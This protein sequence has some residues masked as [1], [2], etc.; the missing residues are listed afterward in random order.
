MI[1]RAQGGSLSKVQVRYF[2]DSDSE[3]EFRSARIS[4]DGDVNATV[5]LHRKLAI[6][7][8]QRQHQPS[9]KHR[10]R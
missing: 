6:I 2:H 4:C 7:T 8:T 1:F 10:Q 5:R 9:E 3:I